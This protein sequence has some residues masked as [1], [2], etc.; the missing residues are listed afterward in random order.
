MADL[1]GTCA[2]A[3]PVVASVV[4]RVGKGTAIRSRAGQ[5]VV[6][7]RQRVANA[8]NKCALFGHGELLGQVAATPCFIQSISVYLGLDD[9]SLEP[10]VQIVR[11]SLLR[12][13]PGTGADTVSRVDRRLTGPRLCA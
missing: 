6:A 1:R 8:I 5:N 7:R 9:G 12:T 2:V 3:R 13:E 4:R 11:E 10:A